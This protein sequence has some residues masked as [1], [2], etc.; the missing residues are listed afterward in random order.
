LIPGIIAVGMALD[1]TTRLIPIDRFSFRA[2]EAMT[3]AGG[4]TGPFGPDRVYRNPRSY[5]DLGRP[6]QYRH[7]RQHRLEDFSTDHWGFRNTVPPPPGRVDWLLVGDSF[8]AGSGV[9]DGATL[10]SQVARLSGEGVYN[11]SASLPLPLRDIEFTCD[12]LGMKQGRVIY[13][14]MERQEMPTVAADGASRHFTN[15]PPARRRWERYRMWSRDAGIGRLNILA[16]WGWEAVTTTIGL[17]SE[18]AKSPSAAELT[19]VRRELANGQPMLFYGGEIAVASERDR[20]F[21]P[22][23]LVWLRSELAQR[24]LELVVLLVPTKYVVYGP[25]VKDRNGDTPS[26]LP[27]RRLAER[28][29]AQ[30]VFVVNLTSALRKQAADDL[31]RN[32]YVYFIDDTHWNDRGISVAAQALMDA[33]RA[34]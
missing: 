10:A 9:G 8:G 23:Y 4:P 17:P 11:A 15:G 32:E 25:L 33:W 31:Y 2:W 34:R 13:E 30:D 5:G 22:D 26:G 29:K 24:N 12:R 19:I 6:P 18:G 27:L 14:F 16:E 21:S 20:T 7:L 28:L 3:V 1:A